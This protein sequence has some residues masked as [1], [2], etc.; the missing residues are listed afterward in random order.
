MSPLPSTFS[1][2]A[3]L[4]EILSWHCSISSTLL[5][6]DWISPHQT[7]VL[8][9]YLLKL[10]LTFAT[11]IY[12][13]VLQSAHL[14]DRTSHTLECHRLSN[15]AWSIC[16]SSHQ[17]RSKSIYECSNTV[18][19]LSWQLHFLMWQSWLRQHHYGCYFHVNSH[20]QLSIWKYLLFP[21]LY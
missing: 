4:S 5:A 14:K 10:S 15:R 6:K 20:F 12:W 17:E 2:A 9:T 3:N 18:T 16:E 19:L 21:L 1:K 7:S 11:T 8:L 13:S